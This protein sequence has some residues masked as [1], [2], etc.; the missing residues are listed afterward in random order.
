VNDAP[1]LKAADIGIAMGVR[2]TDVA[3]EAAS[4]GIVDDNFTSIVAAVRPGWRIFDNI[5]KA[6]AYILPVFFD[7][8]IW[9]QNLKI[10]GRNARR[11]IHESLYEMCCPI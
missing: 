5:K 9:N 6:F 7:L 4:L 11:R 8:P 10:R 2:S 1:A 3:H